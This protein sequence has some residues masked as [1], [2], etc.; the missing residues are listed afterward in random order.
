MI[1]FLEVDH[2]FR[3]DQIRKAVDEF[4]EEDYVF[5]TTDQIEVW[6]GLKHKLEAR[7]NKVGAIFCSL[8]KLDKMPA[9]LK[10]GGILVM[11]KLSAY[12]HN[13]GF[14]LSDKVMYWKHLLSIA[15]PQKFGDT[16][17]DENWYEEKWLRWDYESNNEDLGISEQ[18]K[19][20]K[21]VPY[22]F[23]ELP[24]IIKEKYSV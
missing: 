17:S 8:S 13:F 15:A 21:A 18:G 7:P 24:E 3:S 10:H 6:K 1:L 22:D 16:V 20:L 2:I 12:V 23:N 11:P 5:A 9:T 4:V 19:N 14:A